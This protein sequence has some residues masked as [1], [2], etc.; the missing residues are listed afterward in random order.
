MVLPSRLNCVRAA[1]DLAVIL[2]ANAELCL[3]ADWD[4][5]RWLGVTS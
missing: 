5:F 3:T 2:A 1:R 4:R